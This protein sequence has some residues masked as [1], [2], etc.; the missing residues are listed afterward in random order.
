MGL[1]LSSHLTSLHTDALAARTVAVLVGTEK[2]SQ[3]GQSLW[4]SMRLY[5]CCSFG[6]PGSLL[7][8]LF[9]TYLLSQGVERKGKIMYPNWIISWKKSLNSDSLL[10]SWVSV[11]F[12]GEA[13]DP[14]APGHLNTTGNPQLCLRKLSSPGNF[15]SSWLA[16]RTPPT[17]TKHDQLSDIPSVLLSLPGNPEG[18]DVL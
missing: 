6:H 12:P 5:V 13:P 10:S 3:G 8:W 1:G 2:N 9:P 17:S 11:Q 4:F 7:N 18:K 16:S 15:A 14:Q